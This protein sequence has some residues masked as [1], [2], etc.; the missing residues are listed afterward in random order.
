MIESDKGHGKHIILQHGTECQT[1]YANLSKFAV[2]TGTIVK[3]GQ[4]IAYSGNTG[5]STAPHLHYEV[6]QNDEHVNPADFF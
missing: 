4:L 2:G 6:L 5:A 1:V 3:K